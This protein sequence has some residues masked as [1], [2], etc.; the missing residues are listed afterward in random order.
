[1]F[2]LVLSLT[3]MATAQDA[4][5]KRGEQARPAGQM[6]GAARRNENVPFTRSTQRSEGLGQK[7]WHHAP[8]SCRAPGRKELLCLGIRPNPAGEVAIPKIPA[9]AGWHGELY[10]V[11][12]AACSTPGPSSRWGPSNV[13]REQLR[14][15]PGG[16]AASWANFSPPS[17]S[18]KSGAW[19]TEYPGSARGGTD[20]QG[21]DP[22]R[23]AAIQ[24]FLNAYPDD[25][26]NRPDFD[27]R[28]LNTNAPN[29]RTPSREWRAWITS[30]RKWGD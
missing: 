7:G 15:Q 12:K 24:R 17:P 9:A 28:A 23:R 1:M 10:E 14:P 30:S 13:S 21:S 11:T 27:P 25:L 18:R 4:K 6:Q 20:A 2:A 19:S 5:D 22:E 3:A 29:D 26:P 16:P 8:D